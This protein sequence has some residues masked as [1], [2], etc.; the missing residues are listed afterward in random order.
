MMKHGPFELSDDGRTLVK[1]HDWRIREAVVPGGVLTV[2]PNAFAPCCRLERVVL[3][4]RLREIGDQ[5][6]AFCGALREVEIP[7]SVRRIG[8]GAFWGC[9]GLE[10]LHLPAGLKR[11][12]D[13]VLQGC[14]H[15]ERLDLPD[16]L[17]SVSPAAL[18][19]VRFR[20]PE[21][22]RRLR[23]LG[24]DPEALAGSGVRE[25]GSSLFLWNGPDDG[26]GIFLP[27]SVWDAA[28]LGCGN[29][30]RAAGEEL[31][32][33]LETIGRESRVARELADGVLAPLKP[34]WGG[35]RCRA[36]PEK[37]P[38][39]YYPEAVQEASLRLPAL[40]ASTAK[41]DFHAFAL[42]LQSLELLRDLSSFPCSG[43]DETVWGVVALIG[44]DLDDADFESD[45][46]ENTASW[47]RAVDA[48]A[49]RL[50]GLGM[51]TGVGEAFWRKAIQEATGLDF[52]S[53]GW[54]PDAERLLKRLE[55]AVDLDCPDAMPAA[56]SFREWRALEKESE[57]LAPEERCRR[58][59]AIASRG[60]RFAGPLAGGV[61]SPFV[62]GPF[63]DGWA[64][65][66]DEEG[67]AW[68]LHERISTW[69]RDAD[70]LWRRQDSATTVRAAQPFRAELARA[71]VESGHP[72][73]RYFALYNEYDRLPLPFGPSLDEFVSLCRAGEP[74]ALASLARA[75]LGGDWRGDAY[76]LWRI[77]PDPLGV[78]DLAAF[79]EGVFRKLAAAG[80]AFGCFY[81]GQIAWKRA[82]DR[83]EA[84][85][86]RRSG[87][88]ETRL[89]FLDR[90]RLFLEVP[91]EEADRWF[92][93]GA[94]LGGRGAR[95]CESTLAW[96]AAGRRAA[97]TGNG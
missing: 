8:R 83:L 80:D 7:D 92:R 69:K 22:E 58:I 82:F 94:A 19:P 75:V 85:R 86:A 32:C 23:E 76:G 31:V 36:F 89:R 9:A 24:W 88:T 74:L 38:P 79:A 16:S 3:P 51:K 68:M 21:T 50:L 84:I 90:D 70:G 93:R 48:A 65:T 54:S 17:E 14:R 62:L 96:R 18:S 60:W 13:G 66:G 43:L 25:I 46:C 97:A 47:R 15:L 5:A 39:P 29:R 45:T 53:A 10:R 57:F 95:E 12:E 71:A 59:A 61:P 1:C 28:L 87:G 4:P 67:V 2:G 49:D 77:A 91:C 52:F 26:T 44:C 72:V 41:G 78:K 40:F 63:L 73:A 33:L 56:D 55:T 64:R 37:P 34:F 20:I 27:P 30:R 81:L 11:L 35:G 42:A 6:F